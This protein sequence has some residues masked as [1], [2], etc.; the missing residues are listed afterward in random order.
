MFAG[1]PGR[2]DLMSLRT[3]AAL[4]H[5]GGNWGF[6]CTLLAHK[7]K[8]YGLAI[9]TNADRGGTLMQE[10]SRRIQIA[11]DYPPVERTE[12]EV[13]AEVLETYVG[14][15]E[16]TPEFT[17]VVTLEDGGLFVQATGQPKV[18][19]FAESETKFFLRV[20]AAQ[21]SFTK[22]DSGEVTGLILHQGG[23]DRPAR[24]TR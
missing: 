19:L 11:Y 18:G 6:R 2:V 7:L 9:M 3:V 21:I 4:S 13:A 5:G 10:V 12:I 15:Y 8:G 14:E 23:R 16:L 17:I 22:D 20:A 1:S 24:K